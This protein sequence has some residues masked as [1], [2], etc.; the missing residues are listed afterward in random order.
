MNVPLANY[1]DLGP[2]SDWV[3]HELQARRP[4][5]SAPAEAASLDTDALRARVLEALGVPT[6]CEEPTAPTVVATWQE[7]GLEGEFISWSVGY[8]PPTEAFLL[9]PAGASAPLPGVLALH[10]HGGFKFYGKEKIADGPHGAPP[11]VRDGR[12]NHYGG[13]AFANSLA[14][15]GFV[16]LVHDTFTWGSR[17]FRLGGELA[18]PGAG[19][20]PSDGG[21]KEGGGAGARAA[22]PGNDAIAAYNAAAGLHEHVVEKYCRLLGTTYSAVVSREDRMA[23]SY[24]GSRPE[25]D[26]DRL[27]CIGLSGGGLRAGMLQ[28]SSP[29]I[30]AAV[31]V[32][33][34]TTYEG[35]LDH[36]VV[37]HTWMLFPAGWPALGDWPEL[38]GCRPSSPLLVQYDRDDELFTMGGM[39]AADQRLRQLYEAAGN[40]AGYTGKFYDGPHKF[41]LEMQHDAFAWLSSRLGRPRSGS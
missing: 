3:G 29:K 33:L 24:L 31:A 13:R 15:E 37:S 30:S 12:E 18:V 8:G 25:V 11:A 38:V 9:R 20:G 2:Y 26:G 4:G 1:R 27:G 34:M 23:L 35:L 21:A 16:V 41:D 22:A 5:W 7:E 6:S 10:D 36:N 19:P 14:R 17:R 39:T 40:P 32:G 28:A